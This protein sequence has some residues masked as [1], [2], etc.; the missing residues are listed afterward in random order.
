MR[1]SADIRKAFLDYFENKGHTV[2]SSSSLVPVNDPTLLFTNAG[3]N[4][5]KD[6]FLGIDK[7]SYS[8]ASTS[9]K[10]VRAG[11]K[12]NDL[13]TVGRTAR[14]HTFFEMLGNFSFGDYFKREAIQYAW[15]FLTELAGLPKERLWITV[16]R[17][18]DEAEILWQE[19]AKVAPE[20]ILRMDEKDNFWA[21]G[22]TGPCG[23]CSEIHYDRGEEY[24]CNK[25]ECALGVCDCDRWL[26]VWNLV[27]MQ[28]NRDEEGNLTPLPRPSID[29][30]MGLERLTSLLQGVNSNFDT[31][32]FVP[33][34]KSIEKM[35]GLKYDRGE[36]GFPF[37][38]IADHS[39]ACTFL[40]SDGV[41]PSN[42]GRGYV[43]R[44]ILRRAVRFGRSLG[45]QEA[46]LYKNVDVVVSLMEDA[47]PEL[48]EKK[49]FVKE[50]IKMEE[51]RFLLTLNEGLKKVEEI[52]AGVKDEGSNMI[53]GAEAFMLYDTYGFPLDLTEDMAEENRL[54]VDTE[55]FNRMMEEQRERARQANKSTGAFAQ[56]LIISEL[57]QGLNAG[58]TIFTGYENTQDQSWITAIIKDDAL[59]NEALDEKVLIV[60]ASTPFY[61]ESGGQ[62]AD[63]GVILG[64]QGQMLVDNVQKVGC[65]I[66]HEGKVEGILK[67]GE[68]VSLQV[69]EAQRMDTARNHTATH[70]LHKALRQV[71]GEHAQQKG[72]LVDPARLR[73]DFSHLASLSE[74]ELLRIEDL[75]NQYILEV[76][77]INTQ[78]TGLEDAREFGAIA[79]FGEKYDEQVRVVEVD[80]VSMELCGGTHVKNTGQIGSFKILSEGSVGSGLRRIEAL[81]GR[82]VREYFNGV[83][84]T[85]KT[86]AAALKVAPAEVGHKIV[87]IQHTVIE[88]EKEIEKLK[89]KLSRAS[90][91]ELI[92]K[93]YDLKGSKVL[94]EMVEAQDPSILRQNAE[95]LKDQLGSGIVL[96]AS[97]SQNKVSLVS[98]VSKDLVDRGLHAGNIVGAAAK[99]A[100][101]GG[102]GRPDMAQAGARD[103][104]K[105]G[106]ALAAAREMV[107]KILA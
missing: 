44:R 61:A 47:Y 14:H 70:L 76:H 45:I 49:S 5:F 13:D 62:V 74:D 69:N 23:P 90:S 84:R 66:V 48:K 91:E 106:E 40:I 56:E 54:L 10:C 99:I 64:S 102:G 7:R 32:L 1:N 59:I 8:R 95:M 46:F 20:R 42:D 104:S 65:S 4:Q 39:R 87:C 26:E 38:V 17:D 51:D 43:L 63:T 86:A 15:E 103:Q 73:F 101:G 75:V 98:F 82:G 18:D 12:H 80:G 89:S 93:A 96:L 52:I 105:L 50:V 67:S 88:Q 16:F 24:A 55:G 83:E 2:I 60:T 107:E 37:R 25:A 6:V 81:T 21:M 78:V 72:S 71:L 30:G 22:D 100:G 36:K 34:I 31:D 92:T 85:L 94:I 68:T 27:F 3:M 33:I 57:M 11:G 19:V 28:Y 97:V 35:T 79:L 58:S 29:T 53:P 41:L 77:H 9:Q